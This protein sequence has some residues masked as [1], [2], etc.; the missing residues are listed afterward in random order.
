M[1][2]PPSL[3]RSVVLWGR[4]EAMRSRTSAAALGGAVDDSLF[5]C[6]AGS[7]RRRHAYSTL[8]RAELPVVPKGSDRIRI[9][10]GRTAPE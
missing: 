1:R 2:P 6:K 5:A 7:S 10:P 4:C 9:L 3:T 8:P